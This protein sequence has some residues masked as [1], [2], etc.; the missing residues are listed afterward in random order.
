[1]SRKSRLSKLL[2]HFVNGSRTIESLSDVGL[3]LDVLRNQPERL[4]V[5]EM[6]VSNPPGLNTIRKFVRVDVSVE[7]INGP[8]AALLTYLGEPGLEQLCNG[9]FLRNLISTLIDPPT[10]WNALIEA[11]RNGLLNR[12]A[13]IA[14][15]WLLF[16][17]MSSSLSAAVRQIALQVTRDRSFLDS[18][19]FELRALGCKIEHSLNLTTTNIPYRAEYKPGGRHDNDFEDFRKISIMPTPDEMA[20]TELPFY[21]K[22]DEVYEAAIDH[23]PLIHYDNQFRLLREDLLA[24]LRNDFQIA[25]G[26]KQG[27][28]TGLLIHGL[29]FGGIDG[30]VPPRRKPCSLIFLCKHGLPNLSSLSPPK[31]RDFLG[32]NP[33]YLKHQSFGCLLSGNEI[34]AFA[35]LDRNESL[36]GL[37]EP[38]LVLDISGT[39]TLVRVLSLAKEGRKFRFVVV[40]TPVFAFEPILQR[41]QEKTDF[42]LANCLLSPTPVDLPLTMDSTMSHMANEIKNTK[43]WNVNEV[44][45]IQK[46]ISLDPSQLVS[47][48]SALTQSVSLIQ[49][50][51]GKELPGN[52]TTDQINDVFLLGTGKSFIGALLTKIWHDYSTQDTILVLT[53]TNHALDQFLE[54]L[55]DIGIPDD[56]IV[57]LGGKSSEK[58]K[59]LRLTE[60]NSNGR[61]PLFSQTH[62]NAGRKLMGDAWNDLQICTKRLQAPKVD[63]REILQFLEFE[64]RDF[65]GAFDVS[66]K[67]QTID[68]RYL[69]D[70]WIA[71][72][73][74]GIFQSEIRQEHVHVWQIDP[75]TRKAYVSKW[76]EASTRENIADVA[77]IFEQYNG[78]A[79]DVDDYYYYGK[80]AALLK[81]KRLIG[82]TTTAA[83]K[84]IKALTAARPTVILVEEAGEVLESH[85]L[86]A[87]TQ[88]TKQLVMIGD[89]QQ[90]RPKIHSHRLTVEM[91]E[92]YDLNMSLFE[93]LVKNNFPHTTLTTQHR[94]CPQ[95]SHLIRKLTYPNL[96]DAAKTRRR[97]RLLGFQKRIIFASHS[98]PETHFSQITER[99]DPTTKGTRQNPFEVQM[100][101]KCVRYLAQQ[102]YGT[103]KIVVLTPYLGQLNLLRRELSKSNDPVLNDLDSY[104]L[105]RAGLATEASAVVTKQPIRISTIGRFLLKVFFEFVC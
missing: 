22:A 85:V 66:N 13:R 79:R 49:G 2:P 102:G 54:D 15:G 72:R 90:L 69:V 43:G 59:K 53:Y 60:Q 86:A 96:R 39:D 26:L 91:G 23:R 7:F 50:P 38:Q 20:S 101:L 35:T 104:D 62:V 45:G 100:V 95:I 64:H 10:F 68:P 97:P 46:R 3:F 67:G 65:H 17:G 21:R 25:Q 37:Y 94:M 5:V 42:P 4:Q 1:M 16:H 70:R 99:R 105:V 63:T 24:E 81:N 71:G 14:F 78:I 77:S 8:T 58:T 27:H 75:D 76:S 57:R 6:L 92:G 28:G 44:L 19:I 56:S 52:L 47:L 11:H 12:S 93:R 98:H 61:N 83:A 40:E 51:P 103:D 41:L 9:Q 88:D 29:E 87:M 48:I 74:A 55:M 82:C 84:S 34:V 89:H 31:R 33:T 36:L 18:P 80:N 32:E 30:G 73:N